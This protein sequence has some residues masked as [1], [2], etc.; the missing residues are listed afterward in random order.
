V[1]EFSSKHALQVQRHEEHRKLYKTYWQEISVGDKVTFSTISEI[2]EQKKEKK[3][4]ITLVCFK[5][6]FFY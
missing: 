5:P 3:R 1:E 2:S 4:K 6:F